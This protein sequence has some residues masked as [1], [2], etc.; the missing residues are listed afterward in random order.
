VLVVDDEAPILEQVVECFQLARIS[1]A[2]S[3][4][5][6]SALRLLAE[7]LRP[8]IVLSDLRMPELD[9]LGLAAQLKRL[10]PA[11]QPELIFFSGHATL[12]DAI[13][14][15][16]LGARDLLVKPVDRDKLL[17]SVT[18]VLDVRAR[19]RGDAALGGAG[20]D[21][22]PSSAGTSGDAELKRAALEAL[23]GM[24]KVRSKYLPEEIFSD[25]CW[26]MLLDLY[27]ARLTSTQVTITKLGMT[28]GVPLST[29]L[30]R[31][32]EL[33]AHGLIDR[34]E[35]TT[36]RRRT[37]VTLTDHGLVALDSFFEAYSG[38]REP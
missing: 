8:S 17:R 10:G 37:Y 16:K 35:D 27:E 3:S 13:E 19:G 2:A 1:C 22:K 25:P 11:V 12:Q 6:I 26:E 32:G 21:L 34:Q 38:R 23:R 14:A 28:S 9:G 7:G 24:R 33:R 4:D 15:I 30:R 18:A 20:A 29:A 5:G 36:D 31:I